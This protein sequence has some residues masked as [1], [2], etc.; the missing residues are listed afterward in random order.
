MNGITPRSGQGISLICLSVIICVLS[1][2]CISGSYLNQ[3]EALLPEVTVME[4]GIDN[5][6]CLLLKT[7]LL[8]LGRQQ[9]V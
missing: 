6:G 5:T 4:F 2:L 3:L 9:E 1:S 7:G 8:E